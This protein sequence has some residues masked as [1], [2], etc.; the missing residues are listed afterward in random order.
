MIPITLIASVALVLCV[1][2]FFAY[3]KAKDHMH[4]QE[5]RELYT[6]VQ[7]PE[8]APMLAATPEVEDN[9]KGYTEEREILHVLGRDE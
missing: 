5:R 3:L 6:R 2:E 7:T 4:H 8:Y 1:R 9:G